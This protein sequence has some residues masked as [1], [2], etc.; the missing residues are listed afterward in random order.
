[1]PP[2]KA[3]RFFALVAEESKPTIGE[4]VASVE[5]AVLPP[6]LKNPLRLWGAGKLARALA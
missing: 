3:T 2:S 1:M 6:T 5:G 4:T